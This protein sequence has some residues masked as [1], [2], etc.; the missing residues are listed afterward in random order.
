MRSAEGKDISIIW[1]SFLMKTVGLWLATD[2]LEQRRRNFAL[3]YTLGAIVIATG[4][5]MRDIYFSWGN[6]SD[7]VYIMCNILYL[8]IVFFKITALYAHKTEFFKLVRYTQKNFWHSNYDYREKLI[9]KD[10]K[11][12]CTIFIVAVS[13]C[14]QGTCAG[15]MVTPL[16]ANIGK[17][18]SERV[19][20]FNMWIDFPTG[21]SPYFEVLFIVQILCVYHVGVCYICFDNFLC[22]ANLHVASQFRILQYRLT[23]LN[24]EISIEIN[25]RQSDTKLLNY[26]NICHAKLKNCVQHH[27]ALTEYCK[28]LENIFTLIILGHV[29]FL[30][31]IICLVGYQLFLID[32]PPSRNVS[33][34]LNLAGTICQLFMFTYSCNGLI[35][36]S[37]N[38]SRAAFSGPWASLP[39]D[40]TGK[41]IRQ[42][43][44]IVIMRSNR[45]CCLTASGFF[46]VSLETYTGV[47]STAMSYFTLLRQSSI[48]LMNT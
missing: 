15:Y 21:L 25:D 24:N 16:L 7:C 41:T 42:N 28:S 40:K 35:Y 12:L 44:I 47:L 26:A 43:V 29:L 45:S 23:K 5:A 3:V 48:N 36:Q 19:L 4:I 9:L 39:M 31:M 33:L 37:L 32:T 2:E 20:P 18:Q 14:V 34:V 38:V 22:I 17:N 6:F 46:P 27:Q 13:F 10:C 1:T 8:M 11:R 30:A